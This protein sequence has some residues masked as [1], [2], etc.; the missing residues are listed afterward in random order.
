MSGLQLYN[1]EETPTKIFPITNSDCVNHS[2]GTTVE[3][4]LKRLADQVGKLSGAEDTVNNVSIEVMYQLSIDNNEANLQD[5]NWNNDYQQPNSD[6]PY[7]WKR[8]K[9]SVTGTDTENTFIEI[10]STALENK[11]QNIYKLYTDSESVKIYNDDET[12]DPYADG[13][14]PDGW[15]MEPQTITNALPCLWMSTREQTNGIWERF[16]TPAM[17]GRFPFA[18]LLKILF[19]VSNDD[20][21]PSID[22]T[23]QYPESQGWTAKP[24]IDENSTRLY[25][26]TATTVN[27]YF[28]KIDNNNYWSTPVLISIFK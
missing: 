5:S 11:I 8:T 6:Y 9:I 24:T 10:V 4:E 25:M 15:S 26:V 21:E 17:I 27:G 28:Q 2:N 20:S 18:P 13:S 12:E 22:R 23:Q 14:I 7:C 3:T 16:S 19:A 1:S